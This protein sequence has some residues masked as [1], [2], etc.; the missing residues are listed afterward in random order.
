MRTQQRSFVVEIK[1]ARRRLKTQP[2][3][4]WGNTDFAALVR[5]TEATLPFMHNADSEILV[6]R[7]NVPN[8][9]EENT[10][11]ADVSEADGEMPRAMPPVNSDRIEP[12]Q[13]DAVSSDSQVVK[14]PA[15]EPTRQTVKA[16]KRLY[17]RRRSIAEDVIA[18]P[19]VVMAVDVIGTRS[20]NLALLSA[21]NL[22]L[23]RLLAERLRHQNAQLR[24]M[25]ERFGITSRA[26]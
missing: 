3:S 13:H 14:A 21:E 4:I 6:S 19:S 23:K 24:K 17:T 8:G 15:S 20:D 26:N 1:S 2:K 10:E 5:D 25:L 18:A 12:N 7:E 9:L 11:V 16:L 22:R